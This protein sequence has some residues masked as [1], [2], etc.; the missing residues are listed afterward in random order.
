MEDNT[1]IMSAGR[2]PPRPGDN[3]KR[4]PYLSLLWLDVRTRG[5]AV[6]HTDGNDSDEDYVD[7]DKMIELGTAKRFC[8]TNLMKNEAERNKR[9][10]IFRNPLYWRQRLLTDEE[11][12]ADSEDDD[13]NDAGE[14]TSVHEE[15]KEEAKRSRRR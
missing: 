4:N 1:C 5:E 15:Q 6:Q 12:S 3:H 8:G 14:A 11:D 2:Q 10:R 13:H 7:V 9:E